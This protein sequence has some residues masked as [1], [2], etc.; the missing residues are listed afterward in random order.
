MG[1][2]GAAAEQTGPEMHGGDP[3]MHAEGQGLGAAGPQLPSPCHGILCPHR[4]ASRK[5]F[6]DR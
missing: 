6:C 3:T 4:G 5:G 1:A 2:V